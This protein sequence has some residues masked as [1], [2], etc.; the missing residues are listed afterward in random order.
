M[1]SLLESIRKIL[2]ESNSIDPA[3][4]AKH[5]K[6]H[7]ELHAF[8]RSTYD[9]ANTTLHNHI[10]AVASGEEKLDYDKTEKLIKTAKHH[11]EIARYHQH[12]VG[13]TKKTGFSLDYGR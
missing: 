6:H 3:V 4:T 10:K 5:V 2:N 1:K 11:K 12:M 9:R 13:E 8:H 7:E